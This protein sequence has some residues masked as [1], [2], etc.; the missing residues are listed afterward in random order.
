MADQHPEDA[1]REF[2]RG[3]STRKKQPWDDIGKGAGGE[4]PARDPTPTP[5]APLPPR[6]TADDAMSQAERIAQ[7]NRDLAARTR[8]LRKD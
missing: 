5:P 3:L 1:A 2:L 6:S 4:E 8:H 7:R